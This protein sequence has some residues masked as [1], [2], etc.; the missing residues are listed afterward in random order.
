MS[1]ILRA[2]WESEFIVEQ[3][4]KKIPGF[5]IPICGLCGNNGL[6]RV[7]VPLCPAALPG[8]GERLEA[9]C[10]CPNGRARKR[11][12]ERLARKQARR[13]AKGIAPKKDID[14]IPLSQA[15]YAWEEREPARRA[16][17][18]R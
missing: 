8:S 4:S 7:K 15:L 10:I 17:R 5:K 2:I 12:Q 18:K 1:K 16:K 6:I 11:D 9:Y 3:D 14:D 13:A